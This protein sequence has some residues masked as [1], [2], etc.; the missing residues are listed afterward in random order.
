M[1]THL[2]PNLNQKKVR[3]ILDRTARVLLLTI[4]LLSL[5]GPPR[6]VR[7]ANYTVNNTGD[8]SDANP[9]DGTCD[10]N[11]PNGTCTLR[12]AMEE[13]IAEYR[14]AIRIDPDYSCAHHNLGNALLKQGKLEE[15]IAECRE[16]VR[17]GPDFACGHE[18]LGCV[19][20]Q[21]GNLQEA[22]DEYREALRIKPDDARTSWRGNRF[23]IFTSENVSNDCNHKICA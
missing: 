3:N 12:A 1:N 6:P 18:A 9:G 2:N 15:A 14:E 5:I 8:A 4:L 22:I 17:L 21:Q 13:A 23:P 16:A 7:A 10:A 20:R 19:L 11:P